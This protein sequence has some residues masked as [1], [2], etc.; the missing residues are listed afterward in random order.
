MGYFHLTTEG[1]CQIYTLQSI[2]KTQKEIAAYLGVSASTISRELKRNSGKKGY[3]YKQA[4]DKAAERRYQASHRPKKLF[5]STLR[6]VEE[7][8]SERWSPEQIAGVLG[9]NDIE[10]SHETIYRH[11]WANKKL[12]GYLYQYL[13]RR[14][15]KYNHRSAKTAGRGCI[16]D[17]VDIQER[18]K[19]VEKKSRLGDWEGDTLIGSE[20]QGVILSLVDRK[21]KL[22]LLGKMNGK[23]ADQVPGLIKQC[24]KRLPKKKVALHT[25]TL[26][27]GKEF[28]K[29]KR[30]TKL[31]GLN[32]YFATPYHSWERGLN[33]H[34]NGLVR[35]YFPKGSDL[36]HCTNEE[37]QY[38]EDQLN[39]RPRKVLNYRT[40]RE[41][42]LGFKRPQK[43]ALHS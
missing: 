39:N 18:P 27:N 43:I 23:Y 9:A 21:S 17:R 37:I 6:L 15:K 35:Q 8:L 32:C 13:R 41:V 40:P 1:R 7:K 31:T 11:V 4:S 25:L 3:R 2:G 26:D 14:G 16:P 12:G 20:R 29:H 28:S 24:L 33:E 42:F 5:P 38:V 10:I 36:T 30:I 19:I 34:T 22:T